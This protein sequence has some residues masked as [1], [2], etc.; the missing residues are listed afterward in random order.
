M[1][2]N[3]EVMAKLLVN[4]LTVRVGTRSKLSGYPTYQDLTSKCAVEP[5]LGAKVVA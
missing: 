1:V 3:P 2:G 4:G 5:Q